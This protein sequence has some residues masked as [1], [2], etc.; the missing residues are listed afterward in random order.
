MGDGVETCS[1]ALEPHHSLF[2]LSYNKN[3]VKGML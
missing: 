3:Q 1:L 2:A